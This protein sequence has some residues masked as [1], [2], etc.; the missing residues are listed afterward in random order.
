M[1]GWTYAKETWALES[2]IYNGEFLGISYHNFLISQ[3]LSH[4]NGD[5]LEKTM[6]SVDLDDTSCVEMIKSWHSI[7]RFETLSM[8]ELEYFSFLVGSQVQ[9]VS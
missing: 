4:T 7:L 9:T 3:L 6:D 1:A 8:F 2:R 5:V